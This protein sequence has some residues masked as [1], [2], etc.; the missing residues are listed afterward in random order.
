M[1]EI[2]SIEFTDEYSG[3]GAIKS[4]VFLGAIGDKEVA[5]I[6]ISVHWETLQ[7]QAR[8]NSTNKTIER[9]DNYSF[10]RDG[11]KV[12]DTFVVT[13]TTAGV[14]DGTY[15]IDTI[16][17]TKI[18]TIEAIPATGIYSL[19]D[20]NGA[21]QINAID[22]YF[23]LIE[24]SAPLSFVSLTDNQSICKVS[25]SKTSWVATETVSLTQNTT[26]FGWHTGN[27]QVEKLTDADL[28]SN[29]CQNFL[30]TQ[31]FTISPLFLAGDLV[32]SNGKFIYP[33]YFSNTNSLKFVCRADA[34][35]DT[36]NPS[37]PHTTSANF[38]YPLGNIG[39][40][41]EYLNGGTP[42][43]ALS[44]VIYT[45]L[46]TS[47]TV[48]AVQIDRVTEVTA[49]IASAN[50]RF[51]GQCKQALNFWYCPQDEQDY[52]NTK[53]DLLQNFKVDHKLVTPGAGPVNGINY[54]T[55]YQAL[56]NIQSVITS[57]NLLTVTFRVDLSSATQSF[58]EGKDEN[59]R[60]YI[61]AIT[62]QK[63]VSKLYDTDRNVVLIDFNIA[64]KNLDDSSLL[65]WQDTLFYQYPDTTTNGYTD[66][67]G[68]I[69]DHVLA[70]SK[71]VVD[72]TGTP[73]DFTVEI[74]AV[75]SITGESFNLQ[76]YTQAFPESEVSSGAICSSNQPVILGYNLP[77]DDLRNQAFLY[78]NT[79]LD[80]ASDFGW[81]FDYGF[82]LRYETWRDAPD[83]ASAFSCEHTQDWSI[84]SLM[85]DW[86][87]QY[88][89]TVNVS[90]EDHITTFERTADIEATDDSVTSDGFGGQL[91]SLIETFYTDISGFVDAKGLIFSDQDTHVKMTITGDFSALPGSTTGYYGY[92]AIDI[93]NTGGTFKRDIASTE[94]DPSIDSIW[95][96]RSFL[97]QLSNT[98]ITIE[99]DIDY[100]KLDGQIEQYVLTGRLGF[101]Y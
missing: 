70:R 68:P 62:P 64:T 13:G 96:G 94:E 33:S 61:L 25:A 44:S 22:F 72:N 27:G 69:G 18:T 59:N 76:K 45:D 31:S 8:F 79:G 15:T 17:D 48:D 67:K 1:V 21:T 42:E 99:S 52:V 26:S 58:L 38:D 63:E 78:R 75:N 50:G 30:I 56:T 43:Y 100:T 47:E 88:K 7:I 3:A 86:S 51:T 101:K 81:Q 57:A 49:V 89:L 82:V 87:L 19:V 77:A 90:K 39:W 97:T 40:F 23:N 53:T 24:N 83:F 12:G 5:Y 93:P 35:F 41:D 6:N 73:I 98:E 55:D 32:Y 36:V 80:A 11:F 66:Y 29:Y 91:V 46:L 54:G 9:M 28:A 37:I 34:R 16:T 95:Q 65:T 14:N 85:P 4:S 60:K 2:K 92:L 20:L 74:Q 84:Y 71:F 10:I